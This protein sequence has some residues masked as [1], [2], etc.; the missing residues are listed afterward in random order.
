MKNLNKLIYGQSLSNNKWRMSAS[1]FILFVC[2]AWIQSCHTTQALS[3]NVFYVSP[4]GKDSWSGRLNKPNLK[5]TDGPFA[6]LDGARL[7][8]RNLRESRS[9]SLNLPVI[10]YIRQGSYSLKKTIL[11]EPKDS[12]TYNAFITYVAFPGEKPILNSGQ[13]ISNWKKVDSALINVNPLARNKLWSAVVPPQW[14]FNQLFLNGKRLTRSATPNTKPWEKWFHMSSLQDGRT[15]HFQP[16]IVHPISNLAD[17][18]VNFLPSPSTHFVNFLSPIKAFNPQVGIITVTTP[19]YYAATKGDSFRIENTL[20]GIDRPGEWSLDSQKGRVYLWLPSQSSSHSSTKLLDP[21]LAQIIAPRLN[22]A[23]LMQGNEA[24]KKF[25][26]HLAIKGI[27]FNYFDRSR[28]DQPAPIGGYGTPDTNDSVITLTGVEDILI[29]K[30]KIN[31][32]GGVGIR[33]YLYA[34]RVQ[35]TDNII[36]NCGG[37]GVQFQGYPPRLHHVNLG[38]LIMR[39]T[40]ANC[41][42]IYWHSSGISMSMVGDTKIIDNHIEYMPYSAVL[43][44]GM[45]TSFFKEYKPS[46]GA[47]LKWDDIG[48]DPLT[49]ESVK[50]FI[51]GNIVIEKNKINNVMQILDD[52]GAIYLVASHRNIVRNNFIRDCSRP[53]SFGIYLDMDELDTK[54]ENN[55]VQ[56]CPN[57]STDVGSNLFLHMNGKNQVHNN[58]FIATSSRVY[59]FLFGYGDQ[60]ISRNIFVCEKTCVQGESPEYNPRIP[61]WKNSISPNFGISTMDRNLYWSNDGG[62]SAKKSLAWI[63]KKGFDK[64]SIV[65]NPRIIGFD[66]DQ[67]F[68]LRPDSPANSIGFQKIQT[69]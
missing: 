23:I 39:N 6:T 45:F 29:N 38:H 19:S 56:R 54:V 53:F 59:R 47:G 64:N 33:N 16:N 32:V 60:K 10:I 22:Q 28:T 17:A 5:L 69:K 14:K 9:V 3:Q 27:T 63:R 49:V 48:N 30:I 41:G 57:V 55:I 20:E 35:V 61:S 52:G 51:P 66:K 31:N 4:K 40:I 62:E 34:K 11:F 46:L 68:R 21:N 13:R 43:V 36:T 26:H 24:Q 65:A 18:E 37:A 50:K 1:L 15:I 58:I 42:Q 25:V 7:A 44:S 2:S 8:L 12:G 67:G